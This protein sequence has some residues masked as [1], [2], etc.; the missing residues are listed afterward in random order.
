MQDPKAY[1]LGFA[2]ISSVISSPVSPDEA[3]VDSTAK[4]AE[5]T[6]RTLRLFRAGMRLRAGGCQ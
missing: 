1:T 4:L 6:E 3:L 5:A 2:E